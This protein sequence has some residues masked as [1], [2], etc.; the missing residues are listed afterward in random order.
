MERSIK[1]RLRRWANPAAELALNW[2]YDR[3]K[4]LTVAEPVARV[5]I[6][7]D[8]FLGEVPRLG[9]GMQR[10]FLLA[11]LQE[12]ASSD[13]ETGPTL[14]LGFEEPEL[15]QHPPQAQHIAS[16]LQQLA[17]TTEGNT[18][19][20]ITTHSP[21]FVSARGF[22][23]VRLIR[24]CRENK[25]SLVRASTYEQVEQRLSEALDETPRAPSVLMTKI[26]QIMQ[27][28]QRELFFTPVAVLVEGIEDVAFISTHLELTEKWDAFRET[29]C[30][31]IVCAGKSLL[32]RP[33]AIAQAL[34]IPC[35]TVFDSDADET[36]E[37]QR[38]Q[39]SIDNACVLRLCGL[40]T[41]EFEPLPTE[42]LWSD[43]VVMW[44]TNIADVVRA[45]VGEETWG[46]AEQRA[47]NEK[48]FNEGVRRKNNMLISATLEQLDSEGT[49]S[50]LLSRLCA[51]LLKFAE[52]DSR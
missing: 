4:S 15:Y 17:A 27:P 3:S 44:R 32:S 9:H 48:G 13:Q 20:I 50:S 41:G 11:V 47:R 33:L 18:Q 46:A 12:L 19:V 24:K 29:G 2:H 30:H 22:E 45:D 10:S 21:Y 34:G 51:H 52:G 16:V 36:N 38:Q 8:D 40:R 7:E 42:D 35:F 28:S 49:R 6:G 26:E 31:F 25:C 23:N 37:D 1:T 14:L 39:H 5:S 43:S